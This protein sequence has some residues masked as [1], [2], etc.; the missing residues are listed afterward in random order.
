MQKT[1]KSIA[2]RYKITGTGKIMRRTPGTRHLLRNKSTKSRRRSG[3]DKPVDSG[4]V[5]A[6]RAAL[7]FSH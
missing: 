4:F 2:K 6:I 5:G 3:A 1:K 7:P